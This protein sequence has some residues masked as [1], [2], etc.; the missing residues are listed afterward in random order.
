M[1]Y[2]IPLIILLGFGAYFIYMK[3]SGKFDAYSN[4]YAEAEK[5]ATEKFDDYFKSFKDDENTFKPIVNIVGGD[6]DAIAS[7]KKPKSVIGAVADTA[8]TMLTGVVVE[9]MNHHLLVLQNEKLHYIEYN[10]DSQTSSEHWEF[11]KRNINNLKFE[12]G[13]L[14]DNLKQSMS[15]KLEGGGMS[16]DATKNSELHK[17]SFESKEKKYEFFVYNMVGF[18]AGFEIE[19]EI[20]NIAMK[21]TMDDVLRG[22]LLPL[23]FGTLFFDKIKTFK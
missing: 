22:T 18:G 19:N 5:E 3:K 14:T 12:K 15:F 17:L 4:N 23:K 20:G 1:T 13:K 6:F 10:S 2:I 16:G 7:C 21:Q 8:K 9:N 11:D